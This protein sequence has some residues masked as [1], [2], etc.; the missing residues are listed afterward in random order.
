VEREGD[1]VGMEAGLRGAAMNGG[2]LMK[3]ALVFG[4]AVLLA[5]GAGCDRDSGN[6]T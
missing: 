4:L 3:R 2:C 6:Q 5:V 1:E